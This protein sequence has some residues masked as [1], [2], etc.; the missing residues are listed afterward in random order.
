MTIQELRHRWK[1]SLLVAVVVAAIT[2]SL[3]YFT[4]NNAG[5]QKEV[6]RN[7]R[8]IGSNVVILPAEVDQFEY[9]S[10]G[11][12]SEETMPA[13]V[14]E[15][16]IEYKASL[17]HLIPML[18]RK[19][20]CVN[21]DRTVKARIVGIAA[22][23]PMPGRPKSP[24]QKAVEEG[25]IQLG[26]QLAEK[27][28]VERDETPNISIAGQNFEVARVNRETGTWQDSV[29]FMNLPD[30]QSL[31]ELED[32]ISR[33]E[34]IECTDEQ[35]A[36]TGLKSEEVLSNELA[37][38]TDAA[39]LLR[40][41]QIAEARTSIRNISTGNLSLLQNALWGLLA[42][43]IIA[44][45]GMNSYQRRSEVGVLQALGYGQFRVGMMFV[46]RAL[47]LTFAG[48]VVGLT[49]GAVGAYLQS[50][51]M[52]L[53]TGAKFAID[54]QAVALIGCIAMV[55]SAIASSLPAMLI[56]ARN[57]ADVIGRES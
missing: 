57:P 4:V 23:I 47:I 13:G 24:M 30:A 38:A 7:A 49:V 3:T 46:F 39:Q 1:S 45:A 14:V 22:S 5:F 25:R 51:P 52:F 32:R 40:R 11:G 43:A 6:S 55:L 21:D 34:A 53:E 26:S 17:N 19:A 8:D 10:G 28:D 36:A 18:E 37:R 16:L 35:C 15:Q 56:S 9:R 50:R 33:I 12:Y 2:G 42:L 41:E 20:Q 29:L 44:L 48:A 54:W 27:L 31:F